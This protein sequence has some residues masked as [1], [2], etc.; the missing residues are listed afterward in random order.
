MH[1]SRS[2]GNFIK[3]VLI[4]SFLSWRSDA[5]A[6]DKFSRA[7][8]FS[9]IPYLLRPKAAEFFVEMG[10]DRSV[11]NLPN[12][13]LT[14]QEMW[15]IMESLTTDYFSARY[16]LFATARLYWG[17]VYYADAGGARWV[18]NFSRRYDSQWTAE[19]VLARIRSDPKF[20]PY[21][22][23]RGPAPFYNARAGDPKI[24]TRHFDSNSYDG[25]MVIG[26]HSY[27]DAVA[28]SMVNYGESVA[29]D[30]NG[31]EWGQYGIFNR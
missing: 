10:A 4:L 21:Y 9:Y 1:K 29:Y 30:C 31:S 8:R 2:L 3:V 16:Y 6:V 7:C 28:K 25:V 20:S 12:Q 23:N 13:P 19:E 24:V 26:K 17:D 5:A 22:A 14:E 27:Y 15:W 11:L 18:Y